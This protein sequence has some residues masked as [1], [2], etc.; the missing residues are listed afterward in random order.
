MHRINSDG[1]YVLKSSLHLQE[2]RTNHVL[3]SHLKELAQ[4]SIFQLA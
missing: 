1:N 4:A 3:N 2:A